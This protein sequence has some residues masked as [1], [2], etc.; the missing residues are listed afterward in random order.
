MKTNSESITRM[1]FLFLIVLFLIPMA[2]QKLKIIEIKPLKGAVEILE[3]PALTKEKW[4]DETFQTGTETYLN[5]HLGF[6]NTLVRLHNQMLFSLFNKA[7]AK[8][9]V[10]GK[11]NYLFEENYIKAYYGMDF[12]GDSLIRARVNRL[13]SI[14]D[15]L[16]SHG[17]SLIVCFAPGKAQFYSQYIP[18]YLKKKNE[19]TNYET[20]LD[21]ME[22][23]GL[24]ILD[25]NAWFLKLKG[26]TEYPIYPKTGIHWSHFG[27][28]LVI[29]SLLKYIEV[30]RGIDLPDYKITNRFL[31]TDYRDP[32]KD[33]EDGMNLLFPISNVPLA[34][35]EYKID[36]TGAAKPKIMVISDSFYWQ[37]YNSGINSQ[38]FE[39]AEFWYYNKEIYSPDREQAEWASGVDL[40]K[41]IMGKDVVMLLVTD[42]NLPAFPWEFDVHA[43]NVFFADREKIQ[44]EREARIRG[45]IEAINSNP[46]WL[47]SIK[48]KAD[49]NKIPLEKQLRLDAIYMLDNEGK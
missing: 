7:N 9:V 39:N 20:W 35:S 46:D 4:F 34:Y 11:D 6:R 47:K 33:I 17:K 16:T 32:D 27:L 43:E 10:V 12:S 14:H 21:E 22:K 3:Q 24:N 2:Q 13:K 1:M 18:D 41:A 38:V 29:D 42:A 30:K 15:T 23:V 26:K 44:A 31:S 28:D 45:Y 40:Y 19:T 5:Q 25:F 36:Q 37:I 49:A 8:G 48:D